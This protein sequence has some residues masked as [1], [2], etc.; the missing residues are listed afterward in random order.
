MFSPAPAQSN[1]RLGIY[2]G[3][4]NISESNL[5]IHGNHCVHVLSPLLGASVTSQEQFTLKAKN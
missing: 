5:A 2:F 1:N 4:V 3:K